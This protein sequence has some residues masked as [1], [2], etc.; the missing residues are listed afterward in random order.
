MLHMRRTIGL[1][2]F[3]AV[4]VT[5][6][7]SALAQSAEPQRQQRD[8]VIITSST[9]GGGYDAY[10]RMFAR[11]MPKHLPGTPTIVVN[12]MPGGAGIRAANYLYNIAP[13]DG[14]TIALLDRAIPTAPLLYGEDSKAQFD[15]VKFN[16]IGSVMRE[17]GMVVL[18]TRSPV[19]TMEDARQ[20]EIIVG[21][22]GPEQ[23]TAMYPRLLN[24]LIGTKFRIV[25]G[26]KGQ[27]DIFHAVE[28]NELQGLFMSGWSGNGRAYVLDRMSKG[29]MKLL[30]Q[31]AADRDPRHKETPTV[32]E[33]VTSADD[34]RIIE[35][36]L[37]RLSLGRPFMAPPGVPAERVQALRTAFRKSVEDPELIAEAE[38]SRLAI[39]PIWGEEAQKLIA[40]AYMMDKAV[41]E[42]IRA[43]IKLAN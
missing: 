18:S 25:Y 21:S 40:Q 33:A 39:D 30:L 20:H 10:S 43:I 19:N 6:S 34:K 37:S 16:Q 27:P 41:V 5:F 24:Q 23:D 11:H 35:L 28:R 17:T 4:S 9:P 36:L 1:A 7:F 31:I 42:R 2:S 38:K 32:L 14:S 8:M 15:A 13:K 22:Q 12:N 26:Y 29:E 3:I